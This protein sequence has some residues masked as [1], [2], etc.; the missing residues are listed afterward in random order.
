MTW[1]Q[2]VREIGF[3]SKFAIVISRSENCELVPCSGI[4][5]TKT[6]NENQPNNSQEKTDRKFKEITQFKRVRT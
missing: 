4:L 5:N 2:I 3:L 6:S 1:Q